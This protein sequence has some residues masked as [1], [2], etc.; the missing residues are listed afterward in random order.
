MVAV[1]GLGKLKI[2]PIRLG[3]EPAMVRFHESL[4]DESIYMRYFE[5]L[6]VDR[7]TGHERLSRIC[8]NTPESY[9]VIVEKPGKGRQPAEILGVGRLTLT[10]ETHVATFDSL[11]IEGAQAP[12][13]A[14]VLL[15]RLIKLTRAFG[16]YLLTG[17]FLVADHE[18][19]NLCRQLG[20]TLQTLPRDG[21][22]VV[23]LEL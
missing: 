17:E 14:K 11:L 2:R 9:A 5:Y 8:T 20:F 21:L 4:S 22:V 1:K 18:E 19:L 7:R 16:F 12:R 13:L 23:T 3:D 15:T 6:G 10:N